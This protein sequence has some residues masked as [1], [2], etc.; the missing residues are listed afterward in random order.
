[1]EKASQGFGEEPIHT[2]LLLVGAVKGVVLNVFSSP[3]SP[4]CEGRLT[5][6]H[7][8]GLFEPCYFANFIHTIWAIKYGKIA[9]K[10]EA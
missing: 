5:S 1:V 10:F 3:Q 9:T 6:I 4:A 7:V 8:L 2:V